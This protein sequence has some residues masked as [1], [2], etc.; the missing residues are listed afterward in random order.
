MSYGCFTDRNNMP[1]EDEVSGALSSSRATWDRM[2]I[3]LENNFKTKKGYKFYGKNYGWALQF[4]LSGKALI[5][6]YPGKGGFVAQVILKKD[7]YERAIQSDICEGIKKLI[8]QTQEIHE[9]KWLFIN[10]G[11]EKDLDDIEKLVLI[12]ASKSSG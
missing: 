1:S 2:V 10:I 6:L 9:G 8:G 12:R 11:D 3:F 7:Q 5:S 4:S